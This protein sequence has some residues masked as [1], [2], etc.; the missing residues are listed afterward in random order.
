MHCTMVLPEEIRY[1]AE[2]GN[3]AAV[4]EWL[5]SGGDPNETDNSSSTLLMWVARGRHITDAKIDVARLLL[6]H[7]A[8]VNCATVDRY[9]SAHICAIFPEDSSRG[10]L[11]QLF[12]DAGVNVNAKTVDR[13]TA[14]GIAL[15]CSQWH[16]EDYSRACLD[17][18][19]RLLRA[20]AALDAIQE[21]KSAEDLL[22]QQKAKMQSQVEPPLE[23]TSHY[24]ACEALISDY[25][26]AGSTWKGYVR[27]LPKELLRIRSLVARGRAR[28]KARTRRKTPREIALLFA[29]TFPNELCWRVLE[30]WNPRS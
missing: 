15:D 19:T 24:H 5:E 3:L 21:G 22:H 26:A 29:P 11:I 23:V 25:R 27:A 20:G 16:R 12:L 9:N 17:M 7:G 28:E 6:S 14:L 8:D 1:A 30:Y 13:E 2:S 18:V 10:C 4:R